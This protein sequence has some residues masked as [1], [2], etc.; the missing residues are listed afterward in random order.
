MHAFLKK[1]LISW[2]SSILYL[3]KPL[4]VYQDL[5]DMTV[6]LGQPIKLHC[7]IYPGNV[8]GRWYRNGQLIQP[9][10]RLNIIHRNKYD[11]AMELY[12]IKA[13]FIK[14]L[15]HTFLFFQSPPTWNCSQLP[16]RCRRL[17]FCTWGVFTE[18]FCQ[19]PHHWYK[20][21]ASL[22]KSFFFS[23]L[24]FMLSLFL[25]TSFDFLQTLR[26]YSW[27]AWTSQTTL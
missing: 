13:V 12:S 26:G 6:L 11:L 18:P 10:D 22:D 19:N 17:H 24:F 27:T 23:L 9:S 25:M 7:E 21:K 16:S 5:Q 20:N 1:Q 8:P 15:S 3:V 2:P 14:R 4:K